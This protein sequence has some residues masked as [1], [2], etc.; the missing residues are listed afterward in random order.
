MSCC[1]EKL[2]YER[3][4]KLSHASVLASQTAH[5]LNKTMAVVKKTHQHYGEYYEGMDYDQAKAEG[6]YIFRKF[7]PS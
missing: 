4:K 6:R 3:L 7:E 1:D 5:L 2:K